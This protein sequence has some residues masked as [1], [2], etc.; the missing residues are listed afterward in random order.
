VKQREL[1]LRI[2][3]WLRRLVVAVEFDA[4]SVMCRVI[5]STERIDPRNQ[6]ELRVVRH[7]SKGWDR[8]PDHHQDQMSGQPRT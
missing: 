4:G 3:L 6:N 2:K 7:Q 5:R 1:R 8:T